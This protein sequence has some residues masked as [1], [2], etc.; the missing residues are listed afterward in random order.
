MMPE[1]C[2]DRKFDNKRRISYIFLVLSLH[3]MLNVRCTSMINGFEFWYWWWCCW[4]RISI[5]VV[6]TDDDDNDYYYYYYFR[7]WG[8]NW[9]RCVIIRKSTSDHIKTVTDVWTLGITEFEV[10]ARNV[11]SFG[12]LLSLWIFCKALRVFKSFCQFRD[13]LHFVG[14]QVRWWL[15]V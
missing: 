8:F 7:S 1:T 12:S 9:L 4:R 14:G 3:L 11:I 5:K 2:W 6:E 15:S 10:P 13:T